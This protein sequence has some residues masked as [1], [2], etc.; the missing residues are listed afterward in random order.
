MVDGSLTGVAAI[1]A[2]CGWS[3]VR[4]DLD[5][6]RRPMVSMYGTMPTHCN[7]QRTNRRAEITWHG[8]T[9]MIL[10][11]SIRTV[12]DVVQALRKGD[13]KCIDAKHKEADWWFPV[14]QQLS[15]RRKWVAPLGKTGQGAHEQKT[16]IRCDGVR[17]VH[18]RW[19]R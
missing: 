13:V 6:R 9:L 7:K 14:W 10:T 3:V 16:E 17:T 1:Y 5:K 12:L 2:T 19:K 4:L 8:V 18:Y 11:S 15:H